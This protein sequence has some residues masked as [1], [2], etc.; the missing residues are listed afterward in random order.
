[1]DLKRARLRTAVDIAVTLTTVL[2]SIE[3]RV[4]DLSEQGAQIQGAGFA[5]GT[6]FQIAY[7]D[8]IV[9]AQ[10]RWSEIDRIGAMFAFGLHDGP[11]YERLIQARAMK[12]SAASPHH[13]QGYGTLADDASGLHL[14]RTAGRSGF[15]RRALA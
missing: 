12:G 11:L 9:Y 4:I 3:G 13:A 5:A 6:K 15:G 2:D 8:Q 7:E 10:C 14:I 1:M